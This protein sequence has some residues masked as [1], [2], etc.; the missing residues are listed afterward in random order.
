MNLIDR[1]AVHVIEDDIF[2]AIA[3]RPGPIANHIR[4]RRIFCFEGIGVRR[5]NQ[6]SARPER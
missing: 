5:N 3:E 2:A 1:V 6:I 4:H